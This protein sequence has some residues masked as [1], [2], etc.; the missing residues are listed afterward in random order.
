MFLDTDSP[1]YVLEWVE[2]WYTDSFAPGVEREYKHKTFTSESLAREFY[3]KKKKEKLCQSFEL[4]RVESS[5]I[6]L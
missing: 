1:Y 5:R 3:D 6:S 4:H 2:I